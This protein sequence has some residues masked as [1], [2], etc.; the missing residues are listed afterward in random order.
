MTKPL[1]LFAFLPDRSSPSS[2]DTRPIL[3][4]DDGDR[5]GSAGGSDLPPRSRGGDARP[6]SGPGWY[7][8]AL[9]GEG[10]GHEVPGDWYEGLA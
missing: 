4:A 9:V 5:R 10:R 2:A 3:W 1:R 6:V 7:Q 8:R